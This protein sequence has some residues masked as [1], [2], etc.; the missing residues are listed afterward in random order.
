MKSIIFLYLYFNNFFKESKNKK[1]DL[2]KK[3]SKKELRFTQYHTSTIYITDSSGCCHKQLYPC[4]SKESWELRSP[5]TI[6]PNSSMPSISSP[7]QGSV[8]AITW[9]PYQ[10]NHKPTNPG[11]HRFIL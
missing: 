9:S 1:E 2:K 11:P 5:L 6:N 8:H 7:P 10:S 4:S 3:G